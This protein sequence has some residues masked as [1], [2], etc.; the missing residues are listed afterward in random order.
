MR[1]HKTSSHALTVIMSP[2]AARALH[3][4]CLLDSKYFIIHHC[5]PHAFQRATMGLRDPTLSVRGEHHGPAALAF[6]A[7]SCQEA[8]LHQLYSEGILDL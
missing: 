7:S 6:M 2:R 8:A 4:V 5:S 1:N 3:W